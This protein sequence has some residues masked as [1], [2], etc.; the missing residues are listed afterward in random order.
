MYTSTHTPNCLISF[1]F[2]LSPKINS[3]SKHVG[4]TSWGDNCGEQGSPGVY[5]RTSAGRDFIKGTICNDF[6]SKSP[7]CQTPVT[8]NVNDSETKLTIKV[9]PDNFPE[10][11]VLIVRDI[12]GGVGDETLLEVGTTAENRRSSDIYRFFTYE[13]SLCLR[14]GRDYLFEIFDRAQDGFL[15]TIN[16]DEQYLGFYSLILNDTEEV[17]TSRG[18]NFFSGEE[19]QFTTPP[20]LE[21]PVG[22]SCVDAAKNVVVFQKKKKKGRIKDKNCANFLKGKRKKKIK[23]RCKKKFN[24]V[25]VQDVCPLSCGKKAGVGKCSSLFEKN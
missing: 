25:K 15:S 13:E 10:E 2:S 20:K 21:V 16:G 12:T 22:M 4:I 1:S 5:A 8:C 24:E 7:F 19:F 14:P 3:N 23:K 9:R 17:K 6:Q 18:R 11:T